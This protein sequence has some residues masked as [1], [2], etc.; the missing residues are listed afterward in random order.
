MKRLLSRILLIGLAIACVPASFADTVR[1][2][3]ETN[4]GDITLE[5]DSGKAPKTVENFLRYTN[6]GFYDG[7]V[8]HRVING[9]MVQGGGYTQDYERKHVHDPVANEA[10]NGLKNKRGTIA[11]ARTMD[12]N[13]A[14]SQF[15]INH[16]D[17]PALDHSSRDVRGWGY[18]VFG[19]V[20]DGMD[21]VDAI[22]DVPTGVR[23][24]GLQDVPKDPVVIERVTVL[25]PAQ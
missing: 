11:M 12:P 21:V 5:L 3:M 1:V 6:E 4:K 23:D 8:F 14:T 18:C 15:F 19:K 7:T 16:V 9:F 24:A 13:S 17:N 20:V 2:L 10:D 25:N 22:A